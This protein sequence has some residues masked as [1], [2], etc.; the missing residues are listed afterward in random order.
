MI[1]T[2]GTMRVAR[3]FSELAPAQKPYTIAIGMFDG[4]HLG[5][6]AILDRA[7]ADA[8]ATGGTPLVVTFDKHPESVLRPENAPR[9]IYPTSRKLALLAEAGVDNVLLLEFNLQLSLLTAELFVQMLVRSLGSIRGFF[10][11]PDFRFGFNRGGNIDTLRALGQ[12]YKF[13]AQA[14]P[15]VVIDGEPVSSTRIRSAIATGELASASR[16]LGRDYSIVGT[17]I[18]DRGVGRALGFPTANLETAGLVL[19]PAGVY[20][21]R[22]P[23]GGNRFHG[24]LNIG[25]RPT[26]EPGSARV[27]VEVHILD[28]EGDLYGVEL[29]VVPERRLRDELRFESV[30]QLRAQIARDVA[31]ARDII[32]R[33]QGQ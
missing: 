14:V 21:V 30:E 15:A 22:V 2:T 19:P 24:L 25:T 1:P 11:G 32:A 5:H 29:E 9:L 33:K 8:I 28:F 16:L 6:K 17:V 10:V 3:A 13:E 27:S 12:Q 18:R 23:L 7:M 26:F 4:V 20:L 31:Q